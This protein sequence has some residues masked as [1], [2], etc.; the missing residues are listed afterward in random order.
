MRDFHYVAGPLRCEAVALDALARKHG[1]PLDSDHTLAGHLWA[2]ETLA[3]WHHAPY[4]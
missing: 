4:G 2:G 1:T 3:P